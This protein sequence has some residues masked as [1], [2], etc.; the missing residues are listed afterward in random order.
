MHNIP[1]PFEGINKVLFGGYA[2]EERI[3][4]ASCITSLYV[5]VI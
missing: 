1:D 4:S 2:H 3:C 5:S